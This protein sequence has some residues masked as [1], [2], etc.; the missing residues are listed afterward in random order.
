MNPKMSEPILNIRNATASLGEK[1]KDYWGHDFMNVIYD[2]VKAKNLSSQAPDKNLIE[3]LLPI[4]GAYSGY[5]ST[6][7]EWEDPRDNKF[8][9]DEWKRT[10]RDDEKD[11]LRAIRYMNE[12]IK[13]Y[14]DWL[15]K[16]KR[17]KGIEEML[18]WYEQP[19]YGEWLLNIYLTY[20]TIGTSEEIIPHRTIDN[21]FFYEKAIIMD[22]DNYFIRFNKSIY[23]YMMAMIGKD[24]RQIKD[25]LLYKPIIEYQNW[26]MKNGL[27]IDECKSMFDE[28]KKPKGLTDKDIEHNFIVRTVEKLKESKKSERELKKENFQ[29]KNPAKTRLKEMIQNETIDT[30]IDTNCRMKNGKINMTALGKELRI[31]R[32]TAEKLLIEL[33]VAYLL[34]PLHPKETGGKYKMIP[35]DKIKRLK[36]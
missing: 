16:E 33:D 22:S 18:S 24:Y 25:H 19:Y 27:I 5:F 21:K 14:N 30:W 8:Y 26:F 29:L 23:D 3:N 1:S 10:N 20:P 7:M 32:K 28:Y 12:K 15:E 31:D 6:K 36:S 34:R 2:L 9:T 17:T 35:V 4:N 13:D 11:R